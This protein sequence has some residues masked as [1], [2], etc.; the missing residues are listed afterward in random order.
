MEPDEIY[1]LYTS[2]SKYKK[3]VSLYGISSWGFKSKQ[4]Y[5]CLFLKEDW[6][7]KSYILWKT[8][9]KLSYNEGEGLEALQALQWVHGG[10]LMGVEG[11]KSLKKFRLFMYE[12]L[13]NS[14]KEKKHSKLIY[15]QCKL[16]VK[17]FS[18]FKICFVKY[19]EG[20]VSKPN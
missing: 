4:F 20:W 18:C 15:F 7:F 3:A 11:A 16:K 19:Y 14:L 1:K 5:Y 13:N 8:I 10:V 6:V 12:G 17:L 9:I 2:E